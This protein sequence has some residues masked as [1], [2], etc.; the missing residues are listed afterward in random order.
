VVI[1]GK[2]GEGELARAVLA[3]G[4]VGTVLVGD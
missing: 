4:S 3:P 1:V 2:L